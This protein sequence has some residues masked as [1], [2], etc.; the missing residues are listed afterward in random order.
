M[1]SRCC[2]VSI[3]PIRCATIGVLLTLTATNSRYDDTRSI[4]NSSMPAMRQRH[5]CQHAMLGVLLPIMRLANGLNG[6]C[7]Q[8]SHAD[9][10]AFSS[11]RHC[12]PWN[13]P[14]HGMLTRCLRCVCWGCRILTMGWISCHTAFGRNP[15]H[16]TL[17]VRCLLALC[18]RLVLGKLARRVV[19]RAAALCVEDLDLL[20][21]PAVA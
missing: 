12:C 8:T 2:F 20:I 5:V 1:A 6:S 4:G 18:S 19:N 17:I 14:L 9:L 3:F 13:V 21:Q 15:A 7:S 10:H 11:L 16:P